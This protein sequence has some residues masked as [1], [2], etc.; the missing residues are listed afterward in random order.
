[1]TNDRGEDVCPRPP[2]LWLWGPPKLRRISGEM[3]VLRK[4]P[5][6]LRSPLVHW[7]HEGEKGEGK[8]EK[9]EENSLPAKWACKPRD[10]HQ[11]KRTSLQHTHDLRVCECE[12]IRVE[13]V[14]R[15]PSLPSPLIN[16]F[17]SFMGDRMLRQRP[18]HLF[19]ALSISITT[20]TESAMNR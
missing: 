7:K 6:Y 8:G 4:S 16:L 20:S 10:T 18:T 1:M 14:H 17:I 9:Y 13:A 5:H 15:V 3:W 2:S 19:I 11:P 12:T